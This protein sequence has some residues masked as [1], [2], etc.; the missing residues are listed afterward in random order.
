MKSKLAEE[1][2]QALIEATQ[3]LCPEERLNAFLEH[4]RL[5]TQLHEAGQQL[6]S[7]D[8]PRSTS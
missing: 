8:T 7:T 3:K 5:V 6:R 2:E 1:A 4:C